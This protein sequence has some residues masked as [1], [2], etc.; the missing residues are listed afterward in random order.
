MEIDDIR[1]EL[2]RI[3]VGAPTTIRGMV[4]ERATEDRWVVNSGV[5]AHWT[6]L[7]GVTLDLWRG[8]LFKPAT[9]PMRTPPSTPTKGS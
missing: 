7:D 8:E 6:D 4:V 1:N 5:H 3:R 2:R 9:Q